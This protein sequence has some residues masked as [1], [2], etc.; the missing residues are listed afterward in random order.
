MGIFSWFVTSGWKR[1]GREKKNPTKYQERIVY[2][3]QSIMFAEP[4]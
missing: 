2:R 3:N 1:L 4:G